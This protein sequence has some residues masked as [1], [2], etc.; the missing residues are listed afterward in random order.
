MNVDQTTHQIQYLFFVALKFDRGLHL[1][2]KQAT[3]C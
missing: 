1:K 3:F 2:D